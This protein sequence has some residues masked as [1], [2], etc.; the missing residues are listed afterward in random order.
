MDSFRQFFNE[1]AQLQKMTHDQEYD[2]WLRLQ[3]KDQQYGYDAWQKQKKTR[4]QLSDPQV[5]AHHNQ[6]YGNAKI[7]YQD[8]PPPEDYKKTSTSNW[9]SPQGVVDY[10]GQERSKMPADVRRK[11]AAYEPGTMHGNDDPA[12]GPGIVHAKDFYGNVA[13]ANID[14]ASM[15]PE[16]KQRYWTLKLDGAKELINKSVDDAVKGIEYSSM[17]Q[18]NKG[19][20]QSKMQVKIAAGLAPR[21]KNYIKTLNANYRKGG[22]AAKGTLSTLK[23]TGWQEAATPENQ[24]IAKAALDDVVRAFKTSINKEG[25]LYSR[26][27]DINQLY[28]GVAAQVTKFIDQFA[29]TV[30]FKL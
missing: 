4:P 6:Q 10:F 28:Q 2:Q 30:Q 9:I 18:K 21:I 5:Q 29:A 24:A 17:L 20:L 11:L 8:N 7:N 12:L 19:S 27:R 15:T 1:A 14:K 25:S 23:A 13:T 16:Q 3:H 22:T 26:D